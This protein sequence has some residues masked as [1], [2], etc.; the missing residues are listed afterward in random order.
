MCPTLIVDVLE[1]LIRRRVDLC[2]CRISNL[3]PS[4]PTKTREDFKP[5]RIERA[6]YCRMSVTSRKCASAALVGGASMFERLIWG[7]GPS[8]SQT[9]K[10]S[11]SFLFRDV[12]IPLRKLARVYRYGSKRL[13]KRYPMRTKTELSHLSCA[14][15]D[16]KSRDR[17]AAPT[18]PILD[19]SRHPILAKRD[20]APILMGTV[21]MGSPGP[22]DESRCG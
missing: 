5:P 2:R 3:P 12:T 8:L 14:R 10:N 13:S 6:A 17:S 7:M 4:N 18:S 9:A 21:E 11:R 1:G 16:R 19:D 15:F 22:S 20:A